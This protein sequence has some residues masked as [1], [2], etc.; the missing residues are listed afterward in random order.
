MQALSGAQADDTRY[1]SL[2]TK[3][4]PELFP[5]ISLTSSVP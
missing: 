2:T 5:D 4:I 1:F 3:K